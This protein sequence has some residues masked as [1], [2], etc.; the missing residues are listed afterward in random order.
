MPPMKA[1]IKNLFKFLGRAWSSGLYGK[2]GIL[3]ATFGCLMFI[4]LF[5]RDASIQNF[6]INTWKLGAAYEQ[7]DSERDTLNKLEHNINLLKANSPD[8]IEELGLQY[9]N[10]G[11]AKLKVLKF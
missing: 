2:A 10:I 11:D 1:K 7:R 4:G 3:L 8:Y 5:Q 6:V 9:L